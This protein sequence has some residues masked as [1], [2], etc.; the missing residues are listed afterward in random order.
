MQFGFHA[1]RS[2]IGANL[3]V[4]SITE[5]AVSRGEVILVILL[6]IA[7]AFNSLPWDSIK[8]AFNYHWVP[9]YLRRILDDYLNN[10][11][12]IYLYRY[13]IRRKEVTCDVPQGLVLGPLV[14]N[15]AYDLVLSCANLQGIKVLCYADDTLVLARGITF[16]DASILTFA[17][18]AHIVATIRSI[19][20]EVALNKLEAASGDICSLLPEK[21]RLLNATTVTAAAVLRRAEWQLLVAAV[22]TDLSLPAVLAKMVEDEVSCGAMHTFCEAVMSAKESAE[23]ER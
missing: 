22:G 9:R 8:R 17:G 23:G 4:K 20:L 2:N 11:G 10:R 6:D 15:I 3:P 18:V 16:R 14:W 19:G 1:R 5:E 12:V 13:G 21:S 7:N